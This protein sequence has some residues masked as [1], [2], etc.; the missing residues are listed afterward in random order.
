MVEAGAGAIVTERLGKRF[1]RRWALQDCSLSVP[2]GSVCALIGPNGAG[3]TTLLRM[4]AALS[5]PSAGTARV[6]GRPPQQTPEFLSSVGYLAQEAPLYGRLT[7]EDHSA[8]GRHVNPAWDTDL[9]SRRLASLHIPTDQPVRKLSGGQRA[10]V[11]LALAL[12]KRPRLLLLDEPMAALDPLARREFLAT[13][14]EA[15]ADGDLTVMISSHLLLDLERVCDHLVLLAAARPQ[16]CTSI[17]EL[18]MSHRLLTGARRSLDTLEPGMVVVRAVQT[19]RQSQLLVRVSGPVLNPDWEVSDVAL[20]DII[21]AYMGE[22][23]PA[24]G[25]ALSLAGGRA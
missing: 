10:Q 16:V 12:A 1:G 17:D 24:G 5:S 23:R 9:V 15:V 11:A 21:L 20:E 19:E 2:Q 3:K 7:A 14:T 22:N 8:I 25:S 18:L 6:F 13:L 4:L